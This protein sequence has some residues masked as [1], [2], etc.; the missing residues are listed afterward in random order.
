MKSIGKGLFVIALLGFAMCVF[1]K[2]MVF[3]ETGSDFENTCLLPAMEAD[4]GEDIAYG[5]NVESGDIPVSG[6]ELQSEDAIAFD[7]E[8]QDEDPWEIATEGM[9]GENAHWKYDSNS[10]TMTITGTGVITEDF[11]EVADEIWDSSIQSEMKKLVI[12]N[13]IEEIDTNVFAP[14]ESLEDI[15]LPNSLVKIG[16]GAFYGCTSLK[17]VSVTSGV[18]SIGNYAFSN[19][20]ALVEVSLPNSLTFLGDCAFEDC[21]TID[22]L[23]FPDSLTKIPD[24]CMQR[25]TALTT[26]ELGG[27]LTY[28]GEDAFYQCN[29]MCSVKLPDSLR[30]IEEGAF[31]ETSLTEIYLPE[32]VK[33]LDSDVFYNCRFLK[34]IGLPVSMTEIRGLSLYDSAVEDIYYGGTVADWK[35]VKVIADLGKISRVFSTARIHYEGGDPTVSVTGVVIDQGNLMIQ[36]NDHKRLTFS[37][38]PENAAV[39]KEVWTSEDPSVVSVNSETGY[40][41]TGN[42]S[43]MSTV[44]TLTV[45]DIV[46][47]KILIKVSSSGETSLDNEGLALYS[48]EADLANGGKVS[49]SLSYTNETEYDGRKH[50]VS[51]NPSNGKEIVPTASINPDIIIRYFEVKL[52]GNP[53]PGITPKSYTCKNNLYP[54]D[55][56][57]TNIKMT[58]T[59]NLKYDSKD[60]SLKE[61]LKQYPDLKKTLNGIVKPSYNKKNAEWSSKPIEVYIRRISLSKDT[62]VYT[63]ADIKKDTTGTLATKDGILV[64]N[65]K[66]PKVAGKKFVSDGEISYLVTGFT[67]PGLYYQKVIYLGSGKPPVVKKITLRAGKWSFRGYNSY[68]DI[69][70]NISGTAFDYYVDRECWLNGDS[71]SV[72]DITI[73]VNGDNEDWTTWDARGTERIVAKRGYFTGILPTF[74]YTNDR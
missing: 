17:K 3:A 60:Q 28:I 34:S 42:M 59:P 44:I 48:V 56:G 68:G 63:T 69:L 43:G 64:W 61:I 52:N 51:V 18:K 15:V 62:P 21:K 73:N 58:I 71:P 13:G 5:D 65:G 1:S 55:D 9:C 8:G 57:M 39:T 29:S 41:T 31:A 4:T 2:R 36:K 11:T 37:V 38:T 25:C 53:I 10:C 67:I 19:C 35:K 54:S 40:I 14:S 33:K 22:N 7:N 16:D 27:K 46:T 49:L 26:V 20:T 47:A 70:E 72:E 32:G 6:N 45:N 50:V 66:A 23:R 74:D 24:K 30:T 12:I